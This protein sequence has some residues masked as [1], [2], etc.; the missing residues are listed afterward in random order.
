MTYTPPR[1]LGAILLLVLGL[2]ILVAGI[3][4][5]HTDIPAPIGAYLIGGAMVAGAILLML[6]A[7][8]SYHVNLSSAA[9]EVH[10]LTSKKRAY[11]EGIVVS[12]N[13]A[14]AKYQ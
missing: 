11:I 8:T 3:T 2:F 5:I 1:L 9:G 12:I 7:K 14:I 6:T 4:S 13:N 10:A